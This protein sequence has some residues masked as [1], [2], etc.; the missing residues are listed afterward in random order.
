MPKM[1]S[2]EY[3]K[4][5]ASSPLTREQLNKLL[6]RNNISYELWELDNFW[7]AV[8]NWFKG[9]RSDFSA[10]REWEY[11]TWLSKW[12]S[13]KVKDID[14]K[15]V[16]FES[17]KKELEKMP[18]KVLATVDADLKSVREDQKV[19]NAKTL[20]NLAKKAE[21]KHGH[22]M[23]EIKGID[24]QFSNLETKISDRPTRDE[25]S[26]AMK[27]NFVTKDN[28]F[29]KEETRSYVKS[30]LNK[31]VIP[32]KSWGSGWGGTWDVTA[33]AV[34]V[35]NSIIRG[36]GGAKW[37]QGSGATID[38]S[39]NITSNNINQTVVIGASPVFTLANQT[40]DDSELIVA[41]TT[42]AQTF[43]NK[44][45]HAI[46]KSKGTG[47]NTTYV[48]TAAVGGTT[49]D[50]P[51][52]FTEI[53]SDEGYF[54]IH[55][56]GSTGTTVA[57]LNAASTFVF[58]DKTGALDQQTTTPTR[59]DLTRK[60]FL[61]RIAV[62]TA[63]NTILGFEYLNNPTGNYTN[64]I[65][66]LYSYL[67]AQGVP[68][69][70]DLVVTGRAGDLG[71][72]ISSGS[73][74]ELGGT[75]DIFNPN[76]KDFDAVAN[77]E[78]ALVQ[79]ASEN[80][81]GNTNLPK[82]WD[83]SGSLTALG[84]T[85]LVGHRLYR[86][87]SGNL[88]IQY[89]QGN[90]ANMVL[91]KAGVLTEDYDLNPGLVDATFLGRWFIESTATNTSGTVKT[92]FVEYTI[93][94][95]GGVSNSLSGALLK[96]NNLSDLLDVSAAKTNLSLDN[97]DNTSDANKPV[98]TAGQTA[99]NLKANIAS[100]TFTWT[101]SGITKAMVWLTSVDDTSDSTKNAASVT[102]TNKTISWASNTITV[103]GVNEVGFR[104][105]PQ[106]VK[107][108]DYTLILEDSAT[109]IHHP[110]IDTSARTYTV[111]ANASVAYPIG[112]A[113]TFT[114]DTS[115]WVITI[116]ITSD[117]MILGWVGTT[118]SRTLAASSMAT[119]IKMTATRR[120]ISW[121]WLT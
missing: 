80:S 41:D 44:V 5:L 21:K 71:F 73:L 1:T 97:V 24:K 27:K 98:S 114:N 31:I 23:S 106:K 34:L 6:D 121:P 28:T 62:N 55:Y 64:T 110:S 102:L 91:A 88:T 67:L 112:T 69:K 53:Y 20:Q 79:S 75:G 56:L 35:D 70:K 3:I 14:K 2:A 82:F 25:V 118:W 33:A 58:L 108:E 8:L 42:N 111:P 95:Q 9:K 77:A 4:E 101:V 19:Y 94:V 72:D 46:L 13:Q 105:I 29:T 61:I 109:S 52:V 83:N 51:D 59:Q 11:M 40:I 115:G 84:S 120:I 18:W 39:W 16:S 63:N 85:T 36:D 104:I 90:Y 96:G 89:G 26:D 49:F 10:Q 45:D 99:L 117:V 54:Y 113:L 68:F 65:R 48:A 119:C 74:M 100:P 92:A 81:T 22:D 76:I 103:D 86:F 17:T 93:G 37:V 12:L 32:W 43:V 57:N 66:D 107:A 30:K 87:S 116:A 15:I 50:I 38:D 78:F 60:V 47:V 7:Y